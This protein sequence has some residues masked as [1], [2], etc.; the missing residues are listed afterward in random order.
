VDFHTSKHRRNHAT[1]GGA[2]VD[3]PIG[4]LSPAGGLKGMVARRIEIRT[5]AMRIDCHVHFVGTGTDGSGCWY[6]PK[7]LTRIGEP[8]LV[9][10]VGL[11]TRDLHGPEFD[12][13]YA[14]TLLAH[15]RGS[16]LI[17]R[18]LL[19]AHELPHLA[20]G[21]PLPE[22]SSLYVPNDHVLELAHRH[23]EFLAA[24]SI[25]PA[26]RD[27]LD[28][29]EKCLAGGAAALKCLPNVQGIDWNDPRHTGFLE[30]MAEAGLPLLAHTGSERTMPVMD[31]KLAS[32]RVLTR[33]LEIG[34]T[35][36]AAHAGTGM[37][38]LD[39]DYFADF[40]EM[41][42]RHPNLYGDN[43]ALAG[44]SFRLR[45]SALRTMTSAALDGRILHGSDL[46]VP[47]SGLLPRVF[48]MIS[49]DDHR[50]SRRIANP[51]ER[52]A[53]LKR[54]LGFGEASFTRASTVL[55]GV[56]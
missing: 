48:G 50:E 26:R 34:V 41:L 1:R 22:R 45:P 39:P 38:V 3:R 42:E 37:M 56:V 33:A 10:A 36:I 40:V 47:P 28:E 14:E 52:D 23:P 15:I 35:C 18:A 11:T 29:L 8:F 9:K 5:P 24:V 27:A 7:G 12:R 21:T 44:L 53:R 46:P 31:P 32:P 55:R 2:A 17:D 25:H 4:F 43:S 54:M 51:I 20:D 6:R 49:A 30:R 16:T 13:L 19:L